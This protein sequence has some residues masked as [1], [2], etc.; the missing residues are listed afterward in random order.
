MSLKEYREFFAG[1]SAKAEKEGTEIR[2]TRKRHF[3]GS[4][5]PY[6]CIFG[7][8][9]DAFI[10]YCVG[11]PKECDE[12]DEVSRLTTFGI[13]QELAACGSIEKVIRISCGKT[14]AVNIPEGC[15]NFFVFVESSPAFAFS[16]SISLCPGEKHD[17]D[18]IT[19]YHWKNGMS[20]SL[21]GC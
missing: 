10:E 16:N 7:M 11:L 17:F 20:V 19:A 9:K 8:E 15:L 12:D 18:I 14:V 3:A 13:L 21:T 5:I 1:Q 4:L 6:Y 2:I